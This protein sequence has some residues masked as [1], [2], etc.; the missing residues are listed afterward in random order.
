[1][2]T[3][4]DGLL[5]QRRVA[6]DEPSEMKGFIRSHYSHDDCLQPRHAGNYISYAL[7]ITLNMYGK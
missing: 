3:L 5:V 2:F 1:M 7:K 4:L 6:P